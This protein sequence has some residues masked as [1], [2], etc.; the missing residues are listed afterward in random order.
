VALES[1]LRLDPNRQSA[2]V[3]LARLYR[4]LERW[5]DLAEIYAR[6]SEQVV[7]PALRVPLLLQRARVLAEHVGDLPQAVR[8]YEQ[9]TAAA[10]ERIE[11]LEAVA[12]LHEALGNMTDAILAVQ[13]LAERVSD[14]EAKIRYY[15][16]AARLLELQGATDESLEWYARVV[17]LEPTHAK[18][19]QTLRHA[20]AERG[21]TAGLLNLLRR[22]MLQAEGE[23][24]KSRLAAEIATLELTQ[25]KDAA[26]AERAA[27]QAL[28]WDTSNLRALVLIGDIAFDDRRYAEAIEHYQSA[29]PRLDALEVT[30]AGRV[31]TRYLDA[32]TESPTRAPEQV[33]RQAAALLRLLPDDM[34]LLTRV[35]DLAF[36]HGSP[37]QTATLYR[38]LLERF[39]SSLGTDQ[40]ALA[41]YRLGE[42]R[43]LMGELEL[44]LPNLE[45][46]SELAPDSPHPLVA[47][48]QVHEARQ[49]WPKLA[50]DKRRLLE[51]LE[52][53]QQADLL[54]ELGELGLEKLSDPS[55]A[56]ADFKRA[57]E[58]RPNDRRVL[59][60]LMQIHTQDESWAELVD[61]VSKLASFVEDPAQKS[62]YL[63]TA[64]MVSARHLGRREQAIGYYR[65]VLALDPSHAKALNE[66]VV[67]QIEQGDSAGAEQ[68]L[69]ARLDVARSRG[70]R[71]TQIEMLDALFTL[72]QGTP[73]KLAAAVEVAEQARELEPQN[74]THQNRL[75]DLYARDAAL[76]ADRAIALHMRTLRQRPNDEDSYRRLRKLYTE[77]RRADSAW[78]LCQVLHLLK[79]AEPEETRFFE[80]A[81]SDQPA[82]AQNSLDDSDWMN[83]L[84][85]PS[86]DQ[87]LTQI[88][89]LIEPV[90]VTAQGQPLTAL[91]Y[92]PRMMVDL[93]Q[94]PY[95][96]GHMLFYAAGVMGMALPPTFENHHEPGGLLYLNSNPPSIV[97]GLS[98]LQ[99]LP[100]QTAAFIA[101]RQLANYRPGFLLRHVLPTIPALKAWLFAAF[102]ACSP[103]FPISGELEGPVLE[104]TSA[105]ERFLPPVGRDL[106]ADVVSRLLQSSPSIDLK[107]WITGVD[108]TADRIGLVVANDLKSVTDIIKTVED[109]NAPP[110]ERRLQELILFAIDEPFFAVRRRLGINLE[111][112]S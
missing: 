7:E 30:E 65:Q 81:H 18:A 59:I 11:A 40:L 73:G 6:H 107:E 34:P 52:P 3:S 86:V 28:D 24:A 1:V 12:D 103:H 101:A 32:A 35:A 106:L 39:R 8:V 83:Y 53:D 60:R 61:V 15:L 97:M 14:K 17:A 69:V 67:L 38:D 4:T 21:D 48:V 27:H 54:T 93:S 88:F 50:R 23:R 25:N 64:A 31:L 20:Y 92:D 16:R 5:E 57:L 49:D 55:Q 96:L 100:A 75:K 84:L 90:V 99:Q 22:D 80:R 42:S 33:L 78:C 82:P 72:Y 89:A 56:R 51:M 102:K 19:T 47:L 43:R 94:H 77:A 91:G 46:A 36:H 44:A 95:P 111:S 110:R 112:S 66:Y 108:L 10:P 109:P 45:E 79:L 58:R 74:V 98:A 76:Y 2:M 63:M 70:D 29:L 105:L 87:R 41:T 37:E 85:H 104:A 62:K 13:N 9:V 26:A 71:E 68:A